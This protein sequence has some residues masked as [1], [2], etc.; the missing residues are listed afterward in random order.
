MVVRAA[1][2][3]VVIG[4]V[5]LPVVGAGAK[6]N[7]LEGTVQAQGVPGTATVEVRVTVNRRGV[8]KRIKRVS[9]SALP[10]R[11]NVGEL[12]A[13]VYEPAGELSGVARKGSGV[14][15]VDRSFRWVAYPPS[16]YVN[17]FGTVNR[18]GTRMSATI[19][20]H[21]NTSGACRSAVG[22]FVARRA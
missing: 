19:E 13:P 16:R 8:V 15:E 4:V 3:C 20:V 21:D 7:R 6:V 22:T 14:F 1:L 5:A 2:V 10:A 18:R 12:G 11:C 17:V 9:Y